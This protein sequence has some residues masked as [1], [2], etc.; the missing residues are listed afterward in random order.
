MI[1]ARDEEMGAWFEARIVKISP[2]NNNV[3]V[4]SVTEPSAQ[5]QQQQQQHWS[6]CEGGTDGNDACNA[7]LMTDGAA[8]DGF[9]YSIVFER[10]VCALLLFCMISCI[11]DQ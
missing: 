4:E 11:A 1:D 7:S 6:S 10:S 2:M 5:Q 9:S 8:D 3:S